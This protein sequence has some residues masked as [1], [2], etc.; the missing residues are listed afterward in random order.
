MAVLVDQSSFVFR[1]VGDGIITA[2]CSTAINH[3]VLAV[4][5]GYDSA[6]K[7]EYYIIKNTYGTTWGDKGYAKLAITDPNGVGTCGIQTLAM[8][9]SVQ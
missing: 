9:A 4:G 7:K 1:Q 3:A 5:Y 2:D 8:G 6:L